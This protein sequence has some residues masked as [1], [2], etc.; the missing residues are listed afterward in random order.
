[1][2]N[3]IRDFLFLKI[4]EFNI[5]IKFH[6]IEWPYLQ[7]RAFRDNIFYQYFGS[8]QVK[9]PQKID[10]WIDIVFKQQ[11]EA[12]F[13]SKQRKGYIN[14]YEEGGDR[15]LI[16][17]YHISDEQ[18]KLILRKI[19]QQLLSKK[20]GIIFHASSVL[21]HDRAYLF[22]GP[23]GAGKST[24]VRMLSSGAVALADDMVILKLE[25]QNN[26]SFYQMPFREKN[27]WIIKTPSKYK[28]GNIYFLNKSKENKAELIM[29]KEKIM[30]LFI[31]QVLT[32]K[33]DLKSQMPNVLKFVANFDNFYSLDFNLDNTDRLFSMLKN[34]K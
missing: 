14:L 23:S 10:Y 13:N 27:T 25:K 6:K 30:K 1:M 33:E 20:G 32:E 26:F 9:K 3:Q 22:L 28:L 4:A 21:I 17:F 18:F 15:K 12:L 24:I 19:C 5:G 34:E 31:Q 29:D 8:I 16:S 11:I 2:P 7:E